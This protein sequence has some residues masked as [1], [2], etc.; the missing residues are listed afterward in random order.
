MRSYLL[1]FTF[2]VKNL[3]T[4]L[5]LEFACVIMFGYCAPH[6]YGLENGC[7]RQSSRTTSIIVFM[8]ELS[9]IQLF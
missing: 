2:S 8:F 3:M 1:P 7:W 9:C 6:V 4:G 5:T